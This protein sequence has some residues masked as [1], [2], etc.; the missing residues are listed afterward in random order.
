MKPHPQDLLGKP[1]VKMH[2]DINAE[3]TALV[4]WRLA[5]MQLGTPRDI[6]EVWLMTDGGVAICDE[7]VVRVGRDIHE[8]ATEHF[9]TLFASEEMNMRDLSVEDFRARYECTQAIAAHRW[10]IQQL[11]QSARDRWP[12][13]DPDVT[14]LESKDHAETGA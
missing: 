10:R 6:A 4:G 11:V 3:P 5:S 8:I 12:W 14:T 7:E 13:I 9:D 2:V 1:T